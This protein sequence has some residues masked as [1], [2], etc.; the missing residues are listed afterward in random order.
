MNITSLISVVM[1]V[2]NGAETLPKTLDSILSQKGVNLEFIIVNDGSTDS[3][4]SILNE[5]SKKDHR[6]KVLDQANQGLT[7]SLIRGCA[8]ARGEFIARQDAGDISLP[9]RLKKEMHHL[10]DNSDV[11]LVSCATRFVGPDREFLYEIK[12]PDV[13]MLNGIDRK[14]LTHI[15]GPFHGSVMFRKKDYDYIG[16]YRSHF[17][18]GQDLDLWTRLIETGKHYQ[19]HE[20]LYEALVTPESI[21]NLNKKLQ[22]LITK[23]IIECVRRRKAG[24]SEADILEKVKN[25][26][27]ESKINRLHTARF[28]YFMASMIYPNNPGKAYDYYKKAIIYNPFHIKALL[29]IVQIQLFNH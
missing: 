29:R 3:S 15:K 9:G 7:K 6:L 19:V 16:G 25:L 28:F 2:Y 22:I 27:Y 11:A 14:N 24:L 18:V 4:L 1:G 12:M 26:K 23:F 8:E 17:R 20:V 13:D 21:T 10:V 5:Y